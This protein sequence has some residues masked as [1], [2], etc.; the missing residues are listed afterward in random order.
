MP[1]VLG[2]GTWV[3]IHRV[4]LPAGE[5]AP[6]VPADTAAVALEMRVKGFL[7][8]PA[9]LGDAAEIVTRAGRRLRGTVTEVNPA[10]T[11]SF[12]APIPELSTVGEEV[13][14]LLRKRGGRQ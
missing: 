10:Y 9:A 2:T 5:R 6:Q 3:E 13:R 8:A 4:V 12:G 14:T 7:L 1:D 11:H